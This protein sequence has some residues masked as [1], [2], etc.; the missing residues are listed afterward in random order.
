MIMVE[1]VVVP[2]DKA[3][4][5]ISTA[6]QTLSGIQAGYTWMAKYAMPVAESP[7]QYTSNSEHTDQPMEATFKMS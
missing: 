5:L 6:P 4:V 2:T 7:C 1:R 3:Y